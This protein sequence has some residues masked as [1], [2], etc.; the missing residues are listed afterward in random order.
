MKTTLSKSKI[1]YLAVIAVLAVILLIQ[2]IAGRDITPNI[3]TVNAAVDEMTISNGGETIKLSKSGDTW[4]AGDEQ[5]PGDSE[6]IAGLVEKIT[7][8]KALEKV[9][10]SGFFRPYQ[11]EDQEAVTVSILEKGKA[12]RT[13]LIGKAS[14]TGRQSYLRFPESDEVL[15]ISGNLRRDFELSLDD[16]RNKLIF[17]LDPASIR[18]VVLSG[19]EGDA[20]GFIRSE[21][22]WTTDGGDMLDQEKVS[23]FV[24]NFERFTAVSY[25][26]A[27]AD[28]GELLKLIQLETDSGAISV[29]IIAENE[30]GYTARS[31]ASPFIFQLPKY[32]GQQIMKTTAELMPGDQ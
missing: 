22:G 18:R 13:V 1:I 10:S 30:Q 29:E 12:V 25:P 28:T 15:L 23:T 17:A 6:K 31:S 7:G 14:P 16:L 9:S 20:E 21:E 27:S 19:P 3:P 4:L 8:I 32:R 2:Q 11:L 26:D 24:R 5:Y